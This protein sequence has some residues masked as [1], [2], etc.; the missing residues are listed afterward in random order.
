MKPAT[1]EPDSLPRWP[2]FISGAFLGFLIGVILGLSS[3]QSAECHSST[4]AQQH[5]AIVTLAEDFSTK[6]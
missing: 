5:T 3:C 2:T 6:R 4:A 1:I